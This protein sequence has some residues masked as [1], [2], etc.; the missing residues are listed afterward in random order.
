MPSFNIIGS[1]NYL[2]K[3]IIQK[4][5]KF[6]HYLPTSL[7]LHPLPNPPSRLSL[8]T[9]KFSLPPYLSHTNSLLDPHSHRNFSLV[10]LTVVVAVRT[11]DHSS[12]LLGDKLTF[13]CVILSLYLFE[14]SPLNLIN[15]FHRRIHAQTHSLS[16]S[17]TKRKKKSPS[18]LLSHTYI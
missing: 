17:H 18:L 8:S 4:F 12:A 9:H 11:R 6:L 5:N 3:K 13:S 10:D 7:L 14:V 2:Y 16:L 15:I 1:I